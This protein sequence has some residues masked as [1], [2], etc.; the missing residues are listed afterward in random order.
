M[1]CFSNSSS[2]FV[3]ICFYLRSFENFFWSKKKCKAIPLQDW[4]G[5]EGCQE[6][7][8][9][10]FQDNRHMKVVMLS[11]LH[12]G[13]LYP[14]EILLVLISVRGWVD[15]RAI[16]RPEG[17]CQRKTPITPSGIEPATFRLVAQWLNHLRHRAPFFEV[18][19]K[20][21][22]S[23]LPFHSKSCVLTL[24]KKYIQG[25]VYVLHIRHYLSNGTTQESINPTCLQNMSWKVDDLPP[26]ELS[27]V[28]QNIW[29]SQSQRL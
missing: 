16:V 19:F 12:T 23:N 8:A 6:V 18:M 15:P 1:I 22:L 21:N 10:R 5:P 26:T 28:T 3:V 20:N 27:F 17:L 9:P 25:Y 13:H 29:C 24:L 11:A 7:E 2:T 14:Q 4:T